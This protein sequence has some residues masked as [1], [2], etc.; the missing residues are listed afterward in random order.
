M[1][2]RKANYHVWAI[3]LIYFITFARNQFKQDRKCPQNQT[4]LVTVPGLRPASD[5]ERPGSIPR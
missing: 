1:P 3:S 2:S 5:L 4:F